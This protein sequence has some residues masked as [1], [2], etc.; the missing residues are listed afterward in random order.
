GGGGFMALP[1]SYTATLIAIVGGQVTELAGPVD[2]E[3]VPLRDGALE[4][5]TDQQFATF[6][7]DVE[8]FQQDFAR[9]NE[10]L[11]DQIERIEALQTALER[12]ES[13]DRGLRSRLAETRLELLELRE[14]MSGSEARG[15]IGERGPPTPGNRLSVGMR[16]LSTTYGPTELHSQT[17]AA[18]RSELAEIRTDVDRMAEQVM[19]ELERAVEAA[20]APPLGGTPPSDD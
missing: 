8:G 9:T 10:R 20:G 17:V 1:G 15:E 12:A 6:R 14:A 16:G 5:A 3:V 11:G 18:G 4:R 7:E 19:P 2:F 13:E